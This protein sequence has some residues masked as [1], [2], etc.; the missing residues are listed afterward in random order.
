MAQDILKTLEDRGI[1][2]PEHHVDMLVNQ[3]AAFQK[4]RATVNQEELA[5]YDIGL[6]HVPG[7]DGK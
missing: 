4:L 5:D 6:T 1:D 2:V 3:W 7:G